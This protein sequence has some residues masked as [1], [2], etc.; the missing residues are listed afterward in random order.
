[1]GIESAQGVSSWALLGMDALIATAN[2]LVALAGW[3]LLNGRMG[4]GDG[5]FW[6]GPLFEKID[7]I[8]FTTIA[9]GICLISAF[10]GSTA[11]CAYGIAPWAAYPKLWLTWWLGDVAGILIV[12]PFLLAWARA[13]KEGCPFHVGVESALAL[14]LLLVICRVVYSGWF[15]SGDRAL[16]L[17]FLVIAPLTWV[18]LR[19]GPRNQRGRGFFERGRGTPMRVNSHRAGLKFPE[20]RLSRRQERP[21]WN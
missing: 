20:V 11:I 13:P 8:K 17:G 16:P 15:S 5:D 6:R 2:S 7:V 1:M 12:T 4:A 14:T 9:L 21:D 19:C 3:I 18:A 10:P